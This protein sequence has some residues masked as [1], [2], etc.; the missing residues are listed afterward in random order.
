[1]HK[2]LAINPGSTSTK[3]GIFED[4][5][6]IKEYNLMHTPEEQAKNTTFESEISFRRQVIEKA[7]KD[8]NIKLEDFSAI[9]CRGG[10]INLVPSGTYA[11]N[12]RIL[13][14]SKNSNFKHPS[15][16]ASLIGYELGQMYHIPSFI[17]DPPSTFE[18]DEIATI[19]GLPFLTRPMTFHA[20]NHKAIARKHC[21]LHGLDYKKVNLIIG[22]AGGGISI[23]MHRH[24]RVIDV[25]D[26][27]S[28]GPFSPER[29]GALPGKQLIELCYSGEYDLKQMQTFLRGKGGFMAH[30]GTNDLRKVTAMIEQGD[31][32]ARLIFDAFVY[33]FA[34]YIGA[35]ATTT[36]G[37]VDAILL[38][39]G[40]SH[41]KLFTDS[42]TEKVKWIA[43]VFVYPGEE[44]LQLL[45][46][47]VLAVLEGK[48]NPKKYL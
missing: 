28:D 43:P 40:I 21:K 19:T 3:I 5:K 22:H 48:E 46:S 44:E 35:M 2:I 14:D 18:A 24:G 4:D 26:A 10:I 8:A 23:G 25:T 45:A 38:T 34:K 41:G 15:N 31:E 13:E 6:I 20:L 27:V 7:L 37:K 32:H 42:V 29:A 9:S 39:G 36:S 1:M 33:Q 47:A 11:I 17:T 16:L 12:D 30:L